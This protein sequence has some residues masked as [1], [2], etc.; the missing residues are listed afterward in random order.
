V[1]PVTTL[2]DEPTTFWYDNKPY[3]PN[4]YKN[5]FHGTVTL[6]QAL[7]KSMNIPTVKVA[8]AVGYDAVVEMARRAGM[9]LDIRPTPAV[10]LGA[11]EVTPLE[12]AGAYTVF[13]NRGLYTRPAWIRHIRDDMGSPIYDHRPDHRVALDQRV[14]YLMV[15]LLEE[16]LRSGTGAG[17]RSRGFLLPAA[18]KTGTSHDGWFAGFTTKLICVVWVGYDEGNR[19]L[20]LEGA[21]SALPIWTEFMKRAHRYREY[22]GVQPFEAADGIVSVEVDPI[23]G[24]LATAGCAGARAEVFIAGTQPVDLCRLHGGGRGGVQ[25]AGWD[26]P[27]P[28]P[29]VAALSSPRPDDKPRS[30]LIKPAPDE[31]AAEESGKG[32]TRRKRGLFARIRDLFR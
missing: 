6:R 18:G 9:N 21:H 2:A 30:V 1:T 14:A 12:V 31:P 10:A 24:Q 32:N 3:E 13:A 15:N 26:T 22:R 8:E 7:A 5:E 28:Q 16:V 27:P 20:G 29:V 11:Y 4:N 17:V 23:T 25:V 19:E